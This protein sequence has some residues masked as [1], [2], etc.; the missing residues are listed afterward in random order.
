[1]SGANLAHS[2]LAILTNLLF[3]DSLAS[4]YC[5]SN[6]QTESIDGNQHIFQESWQNCILPE[7][8]CK[9]QLNW[10]FW[11]CFIK[12]K[13]NP[14][15]VDMLISI[16]EPLY[17]FLWTADMHPLPL[18]QLLSIPVSNRLGAVKRFPDLWVNISPLAFYTFSPYEK[19][20]I[21]WEWFLQV[22]HQ[23]FDI[24]ALPERDTVAGPPAEILKC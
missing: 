3:E 11:Y 15:C 7:D 17:V 6:E 2:A 21:L 8:C 12:I 1:M 10:Q 19:R 5:P 22:E 23:I 13:S 14:F 18:L 4:E 16:F 9:K 24:R 20:N